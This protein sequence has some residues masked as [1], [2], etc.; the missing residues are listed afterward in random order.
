MMN[1]P[2]N[3]VKV[4]PEN[5]CDVCRKKD[6]PYYNLTYY[7]H[8]CSGECFEIFCEG[9]NREIDEIARKKL[10]PDETETLK[11]GRDK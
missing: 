3:T 6:A 8:I 2:P 5:K 11:K 9:Y 1:L 10:D 4:E 7:I